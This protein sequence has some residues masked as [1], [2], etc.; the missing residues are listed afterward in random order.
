MKIDREKVKADGV[1]DEEI[2][3]VE[4]YIAKHGL[5]NKAAV[6]LFGSQP[7]LVSQTIAEAMDQLRPGCWQRQPREDLF[8]KAIGPEQPPG[9][10]QTLAEAP[11][12]DD[13][14][15]DSSKKA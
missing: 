13:E 2:D 15:Q 8:K 5:S 11:S 10:L 7:R 12:H 4:S 1:T 9:E 14:E 6:V 3:F